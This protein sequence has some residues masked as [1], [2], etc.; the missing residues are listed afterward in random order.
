MLNKKTGIQVFIFLVCLVLLIPLANKESIL[1][2]IIPIKSL[3]N[4]LTNLLVLIV[5]IVTFLKLRKSLKIKGTKWRYLLY[6]VVFMWVITNIPYQIGN[7]LMSL[8]SGLNAI[9]IQNDNSEINYTIDSLGVV[10]IKGHILFKNYSFDTLVFGGIIHDENFKLFVGDSIDDIVVFQSD[11]IK[12]A[13]QSTRVFNVELK[14]KLST[15]NSGNFNYNGTINRLKKFTVY[16]ENERK[17]L[18][19]E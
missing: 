9:E 13:P 3:P 15:F 16:S 19:L 10:N 14:S 6:I 11:G 7:N 12:L 17:T 1:N 4:G 5:S 2:V 18:L 8:T